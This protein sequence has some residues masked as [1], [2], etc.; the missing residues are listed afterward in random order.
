MSSSE[1]YSPDKQ[2]IWTGDQWIPAPPSASDQ[3]SRD[4]RWFWTGHH[5]IPAPPSQSSSGANASSDV[6][7]ATQRVSRGVSSFFW[8]TALLMFLLPFMSVSCGG[9]KVITFS[10]TNLLFGGEYQVN[11]Q[12]RVYDGDGWFVAAAL[13]LLTALV[14]RVFAA[15]VVPRV[16]ALSGAAIAIV[17]MIVAGV[18]LDTQARAPRYEGLITLQWEVGYWLVM[19][20][21]AL[22]AI[23]TSAELLW[24]TSIRDR[25]STPPV[26]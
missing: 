14:I 24:I 21:A 7:R 8:L 13:G 9:L 4:G 16:L 17:L 11:G 5:W 6:L 20:L 1:H 26:A 23:V 19:V 3:L 2:W 10:G 25:H 18:D 15:D 12:V 22:G